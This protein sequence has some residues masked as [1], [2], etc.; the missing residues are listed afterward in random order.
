MPHFRHNA[1]LRFAAMLLPTLWIM[2]ALP[3]GAEVE[4]RSAILMNMDSG[5]IMYEQNADELIPPASLTKILSMFLA[6]DQVSAGGLSLDARVRVSRGAARTGGSRMALKVG[7]QAPLR[8]LLMGMAVASGNDASAAVAEFMGG[9]QSRFVEQM[10]AKAAGLGMTSSF[11]RNP[12]GLPAHGQVTTARDMLILSA[13]YLRAHPEALRYHSTRFMRHNGVVTYN[14]NPL[15]GNFEGADGLKTGWIN[16]S[17]YNL[18]ST[19]H[20][21]GARLLAVVMG[22]EDG[23][24]RARAVYRLMEAGFLAAEGR[25]RNV[26]E[27]LP[28]IEPTERALTLEKTIHEAYASQESNAL[29]KSSKA[30]RY[31]KTRAKNSRRHAHAARKAYKAPRRNT[32][33]AG[34]ES[35]GG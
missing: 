2:S 35:L 7:E 12:H 20:R 4:A 14:K 33:E 10:N 15:L 11:F 13:G 1:V 28:G 16:A 6:L 5:E 9:T 29:E 22:A 30:K 18:V 27:A 31:K 25:V 17:G 8:S 19:A 23:K 34:P 3:A 24:A 21:Q 26:S 32:E